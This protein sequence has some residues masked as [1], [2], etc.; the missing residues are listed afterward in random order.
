VARQGYVNLLPVQ[1]KKSRQPGDSKK[2]VAAR[3]RF[4][5]SGVYCPVAALLNETVFAQ[6]PRVMPF[7][8]LDAGCGEGYY[9]NG[10]AAALQQKNDGEASLIGLDISKPAVV[11]AA[12]RNKAI[13]WLVASNKQLPVLSASLDMIVC[14]F[15]FPIFGAF[16]RALKPGGK[17]IL[18]EAAEDHLV[19]LREVIYPDVRKRSLPSLFEAERLGFELVHTDRLLMS[20]GMLDRQ[21]LGDLLVMTPHLYRASSAGKAAAARLDA[22]R[23]TIDVSV[24]VL[25]LSE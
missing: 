2:M 14:M 8:L 17:V 20:A 19:E 18:L 13:T 10:L 12:K 22:L 25:E 3:L 5:E 15:G 1:H 4:L 23:V 21:Q 6:M 24:R 7:S 11:C 16:K 9:L